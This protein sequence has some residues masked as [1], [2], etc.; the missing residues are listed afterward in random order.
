M[1]KRPVVPAVLALGF[2]ATLALAACSSSSSSSTTTSTGGSTP[3]SGASA[4]S[5]SPVTSST[6]SA[7][8]TPIKIGVVCDCSGTYGSTESLEAKV[9]Q[10]WAD[11]VNAAGGLNGHPV[12]LITKD[13]GTV[14]ANSVT[15]A[16]SLI[17]DGVVAIFDA[18]VLDVTWQKQV[19]AAKIPV[20]GG[21]F[22]TTM[23]YTDPNWYPTGETN[24]AITY[25]NV[26]T[27][28]AS[29]GTKV[30]LLYCA[31]SPQCQESVPI[32]QTAAKTEGVSLAYTASVSA[33]AP[34][35]TAQCLAAKQ[36]GVD[37][38]IVLDSVA[39]EANVATD[40]AQQDYNPTFVGEG[41]GF[42]NQVPQTGALK[43]TYW[44]DFPILPFFATSAQVEQMNTVLDKYEPGMRQSTL[45]YA[46]VA[47]QGWTGGLAVAQAIKAAG[48]TAS[49]T[50]T[51]ADLVKG[52]DTFKNETL[53][54]WSPPLTFTAG[55]AHPV[56]CWY[57]A[58]LE[59]G[60]AT[61]TNSGKLSCESGS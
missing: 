25:S 19:D 56:D 48:V 31:E 52:L 33:T 23:Y 54:G 53:D 28:K 7:S 30:G 36:A 58:R 2:A 8:G 16:E 32:T 41:T 14:P 45:T 51:A 10:A 18:S 15:A 47:V 24:D 21:N 40:C 6:G 57:T 35:Y 17:S 22:T 43:S 50:V 27:A 46:E 49:S 26:A 42:T 9:D 1:T 3:S 37:S 34:S 13:D 38:I 12:D 55:K 61:L 20:I 44:S 39:V 11:E 29:G 5:S 60:K 4:T 59:N